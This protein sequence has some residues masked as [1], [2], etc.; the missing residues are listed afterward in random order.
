MTVSVIVPT[1]NSARTLEACLRSIRAQH[2]R[3]IEL[4]VVDNDS[5]DETAG[6]ARRLADRLEIC[7]PERSAQ[8]NRGAEVSTGDHVL[9][10]DADMQLEPT[11][12]SECLRT[13]TRTGAPAVII[14]ETS[15]GV[16]FWAQCRA[17]ERSC[18]HGDDA[19]EAARFFPR[20][21]FEAAGGY[22]VQIVG[23][24]DW[25]FSD[26]IAAGKSLPRAEAWIL[27]DEGHM[28]LGP[29]LAKKRYYGRD[30][31]VYL[32]TRPPITRR[33]SVIVRS[34]YLGNWRLLLRYPVLTAGMFF[35]KAAEAVALG[36]GLVAYWWRE[37]RR[38]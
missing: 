13:L 32:R 25:E 36:T 4:I 38:R 29:H 6:I 18:Y 14:P 15:I 27:H 16:G 7:G 28:R 10:I 31:L 2:H 20:A 22:D 26:R 3:R 9:F 23:W 34:A 1:R 30:L 24:E 5:H 11:V 35:L 21:T 8:R 37:R 17:L 12:V 19:V 33:R